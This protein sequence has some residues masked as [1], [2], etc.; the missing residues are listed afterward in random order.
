MYESSLPGQHHANRN[1]QTSKFQ[2]SSS[3]S[4]SS[5]SLSLKHPSENVS[6]NPST[7]QSSSASRYNGTRQRRLRTT[8]NNNSVPQDSIYHNLTSHSPK[9]RLTNNSLSCDIP[10]E[11]GSSPHNKRQQHVAQQKKHS[12]RQS[13]MKG[14]VATNLQLSAHTHMTHQTPTDHPLQPSHYDLHNSIDSK[15]DCVVIPLLIC[16]DVDDD[17]NLSD[18]DNDIDATMEQKHQHLHQHVHHI[19]ATEPSIIAH[20]PLPSPQL[21]TLVHDISQG[22]CAAPPIHHIKSGNLFVAVACPRSFFFYALCFP[23]YI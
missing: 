21:T 18:I 12:L 13:K 2:R 1:R 11:N 3:S 10:T 7:I 22:V 4:S 15:Q 23:V 8:S 14:N 5:P 19:T 6:L 20:H 16:P 9:R 17:H